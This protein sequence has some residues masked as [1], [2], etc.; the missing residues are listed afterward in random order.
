MLGNPLTGRVLV[1]LAMASP[2]KDNTPDLISY[3]EDLNTHD[4]R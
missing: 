1:S 4:H 3:T 2:E